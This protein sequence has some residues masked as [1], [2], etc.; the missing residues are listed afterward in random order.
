MKTETWHTQLERISADTRVLI[1]GLHIN[2]AGVLRNLARQGIK[3]CAFTHDAQ[4]PGLWSR[5]AVKFLCPDPHSETEQWVEMIKRIAGRCR[6]KPVILPLSDHY[7]I[8]LDRV[9]GQLDDHVHMHGFGSGLRTS[10]TSKRQ[11][12]DLAREHGFPIPKTVFIEDA[13]HLRDFWTDVGGPVLIKPEFS[14]DWRTDEAR[15]I[16][17]V[18]KAITAQSQDELLAVYDKTAPITSRL[19]A[20]EIIPGPDENLHYWAG[21]LGNDSRVRGQLIGQKIRIYPTHLGSATYVKLADRPDMEANCA[22]FLNKIGYRGICG[23]ELKLDPRDGVG[24]LIEVNPR[25]GMWDDIGV[26]QGVDLAGQ[27]VR[28][29]FGEEIKPCRPARFDQ[30]WVN[31]LRDIRAFQGY[32]SEGLLGLSEWLNSLRPPI[33]VSDFPVF[34]DTSYVAGNLYRVVQEVGKVIRSKA[35]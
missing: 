33:I 3:T 22:D 16:I 34:S 8:A 23:V 2:G 12:F 7:V 5:H 18:V 15:S 17:G 28:A 29:A 25:Y 32:R 27:A 31:L 24:K 14:V 19:M 4:S 21:F 10:L 11:T 35:S 1:A 30:K 13:A 9:A 20:Q 6:D 26:P